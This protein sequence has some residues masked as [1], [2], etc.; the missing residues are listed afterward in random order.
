MGGIKTHNQPIKEPSAAP[1]PI[2]KK[3]V[4]R[5]CQPQYPHIIGKNARTRLG[6]PVDTDHAHTGRLL[7]RRACRRILARANDTFVPNIPL[8]SHERRSHS[9][10]KAGA[11]FAWRAVAKLTER[12]GPEP[13]AR[14]QQRYGFQE[15]RLAGPIGACQHNRSSVQNQR[16]PLI[17]PEM[18]HHQT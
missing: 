18:G 3:S 6:F 8:V 4:L 11:L 1:G 13:A 5:R 14:R 2:Q 7:K 17:R 10:P 16:R 15:V 9:P 12:H